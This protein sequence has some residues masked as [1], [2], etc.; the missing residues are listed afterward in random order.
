M[1]TSSLKVNLLHERAPQQGCCCCSAN[2]LH[3][4]VQ[5]G[6]EE[7]AYTSH[8]P[9]LLPILSPM[10]DVFTAPLPSASRTLPCS[11]ASPVLTPDQSRKES[12]TQEGKML[13]TPRIFA[14]LQL[15]HTVDLEAVDGVPVIHSPVDSN[16]GAGGRIWFLRYDSRCLRDWEESLLSL[17][18]PLYIQ[19]NYLQ[20]CEATW[21]LIFTHVAYFHE[22]VEQVHEI[23]IILVQ[24]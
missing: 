2:I 13:R 12:S 20:I 7:T 19:P 5:R 6:E 1:D 14:G 8:S 16:G 23:R 17:L 15:L 21:L 10:Q 9:P 11:L 4:G 3:L 24:F 22:Q 18:T